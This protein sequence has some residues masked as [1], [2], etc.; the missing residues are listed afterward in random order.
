MSSGAAMPLNKMEWERL[1][2]AQY[3]RQTGESHIWYYEVPL[4]NPFVSGLRVEHNRAVGTYAAKNQHNGK[5]QKWTKQQHA[6][7]A[8]EHPDLLA[9]DYL[10]YDLVK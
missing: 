7:W 8:A 9:A 5:V 6:V 2:A 10:P 4:T 1:V 3:Y